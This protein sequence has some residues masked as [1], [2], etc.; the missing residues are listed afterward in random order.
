MILLGA[1]LAA[2][3]SLAIPLSASAAEIETFVGCDDLAAEPIPSHVCQ[4]GDFPGA[5]FESDEDVEYEVCVEF[6]DGVEL[7]SEEEFAEA[8]VLFVNSITTGLPGNHLV[9]W[10]VEGAEFS[11]WTFRMDAL[12]PP[13]VVAP[14]IPPPI[15]TPPVGSS[16]A[17]LKAKQRVRKLKV[18]LRKAS[19]PKQKAKIQA[20]LKGARGAARRAC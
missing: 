3:A 18:S 9:T 16:P 19:G 4:I 17:C 7:C 8:G 13:P 10:F 14:P 5:F 1:L 12:P 2:A 20:T 11:S 6:P 15:A